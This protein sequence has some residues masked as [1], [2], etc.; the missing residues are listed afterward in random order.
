[1][2]YGFP[3]AASAPTR[4]KKEHQW[5]PVLGPQLPLAIPVP[6]GKGVPG[7][8]Y[9]WHWTVCPWL[10]GQV[11]ALAPAADMTQAAMCL[12]RFV[13]ALQAVDPA[14]GPVSEIWGC[15]LAARDP[16][17]RASAVVLRDSLDVR[18]V[19][20]A[21]EAAVAEPA[22]AGSPVWMHGDLHPANL[23]V[24]NGALVG[25]IDLAS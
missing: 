8:G 9:P 4:P 5:L 2:P 15:P 24:S 18:P 13:R 19:L 1:L 23:V 14:G 25:V 20:A 7:A 21:W 17:S 10:S 12:A 22:W 11:A 6:V 16:V 3:G